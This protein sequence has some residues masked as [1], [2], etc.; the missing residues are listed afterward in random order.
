MLHHVGG[1]GASPVPSTLR[2]GPSRACQAEQKGGCQ[3]L[4]PGRRRLLLCLRRKVT[5]GAAG[6][7]LLRHTR[8]LGREPP[9]LA[10][11]YLRN[12]ES[13]G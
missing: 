5:H 6:P 10:R 9:L 8:V 3:L 12:E 4:A 13:L 7:L 11:K 1:T 2:S